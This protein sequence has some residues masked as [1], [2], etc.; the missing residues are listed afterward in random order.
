[1]S[2]SFKSFAVTLVLLAA[3]VVPACQKKKPVVAPSATAT[4]APATIPDVPLTVTTATV[5]TVTEPTDFVKTNTDVTTETLPNDIGEL[6][7]VAQSRGYIADAFFEYNDSSLSSDAQTALTNSATWL[8]KNGQYNLLIEGHCDE[9]GTEQYNLALGDR[10]ANQA[11]EYLVTLGV[12]AARI[13]T[14]S[15]GEERPFDP[16]HDESA[17]SKNRRDHLVLVGR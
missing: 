10:R 14:V 2:K 9:R 5:Q 16:G 17:W 1:M 7:R 8:K 13:R 4:V 15:Y 6:N 11:K 3:V 12:D